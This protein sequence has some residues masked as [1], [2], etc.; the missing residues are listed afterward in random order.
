MANR[1]HKKPRKLENL[2]VDEISLVDNPANGEEDFLITKRDEEG[3][4]MENGDQDPTQP[5]LIEGSETFSEIVGD[6][7]DKADDFTEAL[8]RVGGALK[9]RVADV[10]K[11][12]R[13]G[14]VKSVSID[15][16]VKSV[17]ADGVLDLGDKVQAIKQQADAAPLPTRSPYPVPAAARP[18]AAPAQ[19]DSK[20]LWAAVKTWLAVP[21]T[22]DPIKKALQGVLDALG[23]MEG[24][25]K[26]EDG[27]APAAGA[28]AEGTETKVDPPAGE[29]FVTRKEFEDTVVKLT[30][31]IA[32]GAGATKEQPKAKEG[33]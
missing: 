13:R 26:V 33:E 9:E 15:A 3:D 17:E 20:M 8:G 19:F 31:A 10:R 28:G 32:A 16:V 6:A 11:R 27:A 7:C 12:G 2:D 29:K 1:L 30:Q 22:P 14:V 23:K 5:S 21:G 4:G 24:M 25:T 18:A